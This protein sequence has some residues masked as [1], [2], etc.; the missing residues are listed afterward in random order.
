MIPHAM[1][2]RPV[3]LTEAWCTPKGR[4]VVR[5][6]GEGFAELYACDV[7]GLP[8]K[9]LW[10]GLFDLARSQMLTE[11]ADDLAAWVRAGLGDHLATSTSEIRQASRS[12]M[13]R[14]ILSGERRSRIGPRGCR[15][16][17]PFGLSRARRSASSRS[18]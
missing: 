8:K 12:V 6:F 15:Y 1:V 4:I 2:L 3:Q 13:R 10:R 18:P 14:A 11:T 16:R 9:W 7:N 17:S 5:A